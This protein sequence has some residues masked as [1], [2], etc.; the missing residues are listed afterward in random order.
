MTHQLIL[1]FVSCRA[2]RLSPAAQC[3]STDRENYCTADFISMGVF[4]SFLFIHFVHIVIDL[5]FCCLA[6]ARRDIPITIRLFRSFLCR[7]VTIPS[8]KIRCKNSEP[9]EKRSSAQ[10]LNYFIGLLQ[11]P[12]FLML[13]KHGWF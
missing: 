7:L 4:E 8:M 2:S 11:I 1:M 5:Q 12:R 9:K 6:Q 13:V 10:L 3:G